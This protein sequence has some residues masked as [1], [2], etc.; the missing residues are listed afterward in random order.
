MMLIFG[1]T[2]IVPLKKTRVF[3]M[4]RLVPSL[5]GT[6]LELRWPIRPFVH[7]L[8]MMTDDSKRKS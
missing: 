2:G 4:V 3:V 8:I 7:D 5:P 6:L 1:S